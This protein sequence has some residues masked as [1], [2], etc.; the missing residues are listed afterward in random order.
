MC[1]QLMP[2]EMLLALELRG[3]FVIGRTTLGITLEW[4]VCFSYDK[5]II[6]SMPDSSRRASRSPGP[7]LRTSQLNAFPIAV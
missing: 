2:P 5:L 6:P 3:A 4:L 1:G 7:I